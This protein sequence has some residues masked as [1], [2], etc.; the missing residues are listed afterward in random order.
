MAMSS[1]S[2]LKKGLKTRIP[3]APSKKA[4]GANINS[5]ARRTGPA[6]TPKSLPGRKA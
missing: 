1:K 2:M 3:A 5:E 4:S 6:P